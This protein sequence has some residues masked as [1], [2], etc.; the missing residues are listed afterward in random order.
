MRARLSDAGR[1]GALAGSG[2]RFPSPNLADIRSKRSTKLFD[3]RLMHFNLEA[4]AFED[5]HEL[6]DP[7]IVSE[8][9]ILDHGALDPR[10]AGAANVSQNLKFA[11]LA[12]EF[13]IIHDLESVVVHDVFE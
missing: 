6:G 5:H 8:F 1:R 12:I 10:P 3:K 7:K 4:V 9:M 13:E 2:N 11:A